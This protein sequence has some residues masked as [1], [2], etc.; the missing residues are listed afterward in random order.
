MA[1]QVGWCVVGEGERPIDEDAFPHVFSQREEAV[2]FV[3]D[4]LAEFPRLGYDR[5]RG[6]WGRSREDADC[7]TRFVI[8]EA[9]QEA[10]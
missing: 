1:Y 6:Y 7:E 8:E 3:L 2:A 9:V 10:S 4:K 5:S